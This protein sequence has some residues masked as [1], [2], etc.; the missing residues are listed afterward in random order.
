MLYV[1]AALLSAVYTCSSAVCTIKNICFLSSKRVSLS[2]WVRVV[3]LPSW[4]M[5]Y[6]S[7]LPSKSTSLSSS[8]LN[9]SHSLT[10]FVS[11]FQSS[12]SRSELS[13]TSF[14]LSPPRISLSL[15]LSLHMLFQLLSLCVNLRISYH[16]RTALKP[17]P[18]KIWFEGVLILHISKMPN[19]S[20]HQDVKKQVARPW[21]I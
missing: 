10:E 3:N 4:Q 6:F 2:L 18:K 5:W 8:L 17:Q 11:G 12:R 7:Y 15:S 16:I 20:Y 13:C 1:R 19:M 9:H 14:T 21:I